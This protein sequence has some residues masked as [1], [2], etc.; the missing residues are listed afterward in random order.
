MLYVYVV[1][2]FHNTFVWYLSEISIVYDNYGVSVF[3]YPHG[4]NGSSLT[5]IFK[6]INT[7]LNF[8]DS[9]GCRINMVSVFYFLNQLNFANISL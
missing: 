3:S 7:A 1:I 9:F 6:V 5:I 2:L 8:T 4:L